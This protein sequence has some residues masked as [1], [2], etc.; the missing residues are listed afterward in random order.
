MDKSTSE[1]SKKY[2]LISPPPL[3]TLWVWLYIDSFSV[4]SN[5]KFGI[6]LEAITIQCKSSASNPASNLTILIND[7]D[8]D[9]LELH[10]FFSK[11][12]YVTG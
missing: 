8:M 4:T 12:T 2:V 11:I 5:K 9:D 7:Q 1:K 10:C 6:H 3:C